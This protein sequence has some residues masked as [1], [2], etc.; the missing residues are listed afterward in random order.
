[1][2]FHC[3]SRFVKMLE[4]LKILARHGR[5]MPGGKGWER[6]DQGPK[7]CHTGM[8]W[9]GNVGRE[10][11]SES[12]S[13]IMLQTCFKPSAHTQRILSLHD[14]VEEGLSPTSNR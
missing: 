2:V 8:G 3:F 12:T 6:K 11:G 10:M 1:M 7:A 14:D 5:P 13:N 4:L 9:N